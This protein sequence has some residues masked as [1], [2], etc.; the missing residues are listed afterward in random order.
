MF[1]KDCSA[2]VVLKL[3]WNHHELKQSSISS[4]FHR[5][6]L[7]LIKLLQTNDQSVRRM[8]ITGPKHESLAAQFIPP[9]IECF[10]NVLIVLVNLTQSFFIKFLSCF[11]QVVLKFS[12]SFL[13]Y[14]YSLVIKYQ[15]LILTIHCLSSIHIHALDGCVL[16]MKIMTMW[17]TLIAVFTLL[18]T[19][20]EFHNPCLSNFH[21]QI[22][23][24]H[25]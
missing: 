3:N 22:L 4:F 17:S 12:P 16:D 23:L 20:G 24:T 10:E 9:P 6:P 19:T 21:I 5:H 15:T 18:S 11:C 8:L 14:I 1:Y 25:K 2:K 13:K 7:D